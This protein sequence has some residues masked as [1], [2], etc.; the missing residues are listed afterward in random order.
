MKWNQ[1]LGSQTRTK[2]RGAASMY[3]NMMPALTGHELMCTITS[4]N[5]R[6]SFFV[7][8]AA[9]GGASTQFHTIA[10][11]FHL[12]K[13]SMMP[14]KYLRSISGQSFPPTNL[15]EKSFLCSYIM[16]S[17]LESN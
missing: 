8:L 3:R 11:C 12:L 16:F 1:I 13:G 10:Q 5:H 2:H 4:V 15:R 9:V 14:L 6:L 17:L 7:A